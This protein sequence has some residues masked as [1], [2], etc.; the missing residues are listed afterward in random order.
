MTVNR[1][2]SLLQNNEATVSPGGFVALLDEWD[3]ADAADAPELGA[4]DVPG[5]PVAGSRPGASHTIFIDFDG[6]TISGTEWNAR[7]DVASIEID[8]YNVNDEFKQAVWERIAQDYAPFDVNVTIT[9]PGADALWKTSNDDNQYGSHLLVIPDSSDLPAGMQGYGGL[10]WVGGFG[11]QHLSPALVMAD[12]L[13]NNPAYIADAGSHEVGHNLG[14]EHHGIAGD[15]YYYDTPADPSALWGPIMGAPYDVPLSQWSDGG[16]ANATNPDQDDLAVMTD[17]GAADFFLFLYDQN[18]D[19]FTGGVCYYR[20]GRIATDGDPQQGDTFYEPVNNRCAEDESAHTGAQLDAQWEF[21]DRTSY[22]SDPHGDDTGD[23]TSLD[24][25]TGE[26]TAEG[27]IVNSNDADVFALVTNGGPFTAEVAPAGNGSNLDLKISL[28][29]ADGNVIAEGEEETS[30]PLLGPEA[31]GLEASLSEDLEAGA[32]YISVEGRGQGDPANNTPSNGSGYTAYGSLGFYE[33]TGTAEPFEAAPVVITAPEDGAEVEA[34]NLVVTGTAEPEAEVALSIDGDTVGSATVDAEGAW[35]TT[36]ENDLP[37]GEST[38]TA[39]QAVGTITVPETDE[40]TVVVPLGAP[41]IE[42]PAEGDTATTAMPTFSG[43]GVAGATVTVT[44][45]CGDAAQT[46]ETEV[47][48]DGNWSVKPE[49]GLP[50][51]D[52]SVEAVQEINGATS[53]AAGPVNFS[54]NVE[55]DGDDNGDEGGDENGDEGGTEE[56]DEDGDDLPDTGSSSLVGLTAG[57]VLLALGGLL[58][59]RT[60]RATV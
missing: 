20:D 38:I 32:Y 57:V 60:R 5:D 6:H 58:Y 28:L 10:A 44:I 27:A 22:A 23:A 1:L 24:N 41:V 54:V 51:G 30:S 49:E 43:T 59:A 21:V 16:Y 40:V 19:R 26:F 33:L 36:L 2:T 12:N 31:D 4:A 50:N 29:D 25:S 3:P 45:T 37:Y 39:Q 34:A 7:Y 52:C 53:P 17:G 46:V 15:E 18:G 9:D 14:L 35:T 42:R 56:G 11:S 8:A 55:E 13:A 47:D 48:E